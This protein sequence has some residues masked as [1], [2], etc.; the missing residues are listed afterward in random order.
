FPKAFIIRPFGEK[1]ILLKP[2]AGEVE[3][4]TLKIDFDEVE[5]KL[6]KPAMDRAGLTGDTTQEFLQ[7]GSIPRD[8]FQR[9]LTAELVIADI[10][11]H[12]A[13]V[14][15]ELGIRHA[16]RDKRTFLIRCSV[17]GND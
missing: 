8:M 15:C 12:N 7:S 1:E 11:I 9:L 4:K 5:K 6:I 16:L 2:P 10:S 3:P 17:G 13:N 14:F